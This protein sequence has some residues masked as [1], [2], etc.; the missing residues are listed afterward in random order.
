MVTD[1]KL[2]EEL[3]KLTVS[4]RIIR[5]A[6]VS[7]AVFMDTSVSY[8]REKDLQAIGAC[9]QNMMLAAH[10]MGLG[11]VWLGEI[12]KNKEKVEE[13]LNVPKE[14]DFMA[15]VAVGYPAREGRSERKPLN[16]V[17]LKWL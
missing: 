7:V 17:I 13:L 6:P 15:L 4:G 1:Q 10:C 11:T 2:R 8:H 9:I 16:E 12:L 5:E 14:L 3:A